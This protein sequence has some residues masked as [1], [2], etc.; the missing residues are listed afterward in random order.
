M[1]KHIELVKNNPSFSLMVM[2]TAPWIFIKYFQFQIQFFS[3]KNLYQ[4]SMK[5]ISILVLIFPYLF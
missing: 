5:G 3:T 2:E 4:Y 1:K